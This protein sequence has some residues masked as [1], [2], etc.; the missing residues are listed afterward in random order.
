MKKE[1]FTKIINLI[2]EQVKKED[3]INDFFFE[4]YREYFPNTTASFIGD[5]IKI[6]GEELGDTDET[7]FWWLFYA[8]NG[9]QGDV[10]DD[11]LRDVD[12]DY[13]PVKT[14]EQLFDYLNK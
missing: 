14:P 13:I 9:I 2:R 1:T 6:M 11:V 4:V 8:P 12:G 3:K 10:K 5:L 7:I